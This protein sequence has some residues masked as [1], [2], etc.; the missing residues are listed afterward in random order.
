MYKV[1]KFCLH[2]K[3][4]FGGCLRLQSH[5]ISSDKRGK[6][7]MVG[8]GNGQVQKSEERERRVVCMVTSYEQQNYYRKQHTNLLH[9][10][11][12]GYNQLTKY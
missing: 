8:V 7:D 9:K 12:D 11:I 6:V 3:S 2:G 1:N 4:N 10:G 5:Q